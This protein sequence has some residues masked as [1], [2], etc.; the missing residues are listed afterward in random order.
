VR[1]PA[2]LAD[3]LSIALWRQGLPIAP[4]GGKVP[5]HGAKAFIAEGVSYRDVALLA[6]RAARKLRGGDEE[7]RA[8]GA[9]EG[10]VLE[11]A[12]I[13]IYPVEQA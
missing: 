2:P 12:G 8:E 13:A 6:R 4:C 9:E 3:L 7:K 10:D 5:G 1:A 11:K